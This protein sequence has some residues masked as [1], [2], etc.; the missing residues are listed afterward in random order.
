MS[1]LTFDARVDDHH[2]QVFASSAANRDD[3]EPASHF[4]AEAEEELAKDLDGLAEILTDSDSIKAYAAA[5]YESSSAFRAEVRA[6]NLDW[7]D[8]RAQQLE[9]FAAEEAATFGA[10]DGE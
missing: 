4:Y 6:K 7:L 8:M 1:A 2:E 9:E 10:G 3:S 5:L